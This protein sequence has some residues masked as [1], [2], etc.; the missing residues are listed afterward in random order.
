MQTWSS[1]WADYDNDGDMDVF[2]GSS[3]NGAPHKLNI[4]NRGWY[5]TDISASTGI[6]AMAATGIEKLYLRFQ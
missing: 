4:N 5:F 6:N 3:T 1:A 2:V